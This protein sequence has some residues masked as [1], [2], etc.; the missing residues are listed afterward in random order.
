[1]DESIDENGQITTELFEHEIN[2]AMRQ[3]FKAKP[4]TIVIALLNSDR[5]PLHESIFKNLLFAAGYTSI[6]TSHK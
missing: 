6:I 1:V 2:K 5:N 3:V 4:E